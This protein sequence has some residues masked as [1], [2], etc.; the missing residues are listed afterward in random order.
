[1]RV[2]QR[3]PSKVVSDG[4]VWRRE[5]TDAG[6]LGDGLG[7]LGGTAEP[8]QRVGGAR[9]HRRREVDLR[10]RCH[11]HRCSPR[12]ADHPHVLRHAPGWPAWVVAVAQ[13]PAVATRHHADAAGAGDGVETDD[14]A[15]RRRPT[16]A[17][18]RPRLRIVGGGERAQAERGAGET[19]DRILPPRRQRGVLD[20][21][22]AVGVG[23]HD[24][25]I[26]R[27]Q[28][29][30]GHARGARRAQLDRVHRRIRQPAVDDVDAVQAA[31]RPQPQPALANDEV[32]GLD[33]VEPEQ[34]GE[35]RV[36]DISG[37]VDAAG[38]QHDARAGHR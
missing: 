14:D 32:G 3:P 25:T 37:V 7:P 16:V 19:R 6:G 29:E 5:A 22:R 36:L 2:A 10:Q 8:E 24:P 33:E 9:R 12:R 26:H 38:Q 30:P 20:D 34:P 31:E 18:R 23:Q 4:S 21:A 17:E 28:Q 35:R 13:D 1:M 11:G 15:R 27:R